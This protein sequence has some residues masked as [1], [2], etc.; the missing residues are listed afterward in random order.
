M[1]SGLPF[2]SLV[3]ESEKW[4][5]SRSVVS[6]P[7]Q[8][9]GLQ[10]SRLLHPW[11]FPGKSSGV[12]CHCL[13]RFTFLICFKCWMTVEWLTLS[14]SAPS[15]VVVTVS[16]SMIA[17]NWL[18]STSNGRPLCSSSSRLSS[19]L[20]NFLNHH[21]TVHP[22]AVSAPNVLLMFWVAPMLYDPFWTWIRKSLKFT[23]V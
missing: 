15:H 7:Q 6:N 17:L 13:L 10:P 23:F 4:K 3:H 11:D 12:G 1:W 20:Q 14:S 21:C 2:P 5:W 16:A 9:H 19:P 8:P 22:L 18:L